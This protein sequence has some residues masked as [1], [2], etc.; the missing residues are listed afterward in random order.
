MIEC[1]IATTFVSRRIYLKLDVKRD[2]QK[3]AENQICQ[4]IKIM[5]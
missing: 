4:W 2:L 3:Y 5:F 1:P